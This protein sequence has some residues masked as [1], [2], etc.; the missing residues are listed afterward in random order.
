MDEMER[1]ANP[2]GVEDLESVQAE[3][4]RVTAVADQAE[5]VVRSALSNASTREDFTR[6]WTLLHESVE[7]ASSC[8]GR[9]RGLVR[10]VDKAAAEWE[11]SRLYTPDGLRSLEAELRSATGHHPVKG[12]RQWMQRLFDAVRASEMDGLRRIAAMDLGLSGTF[13]DGQAWIHQRIQRFADNDLGTALE[14]MNAVADAHVPGWD[15]VFDSAT[16]SRAHRLAALVVT[17][18]GGDTDE[19]LAHLNA[20]VELD[21]ASAIN[22]ADRAALRLFLGDF[23]LAAADAERAIQL[24]ETEPGGHLALGTW[25][26]LTGELDEAAA[27][28]AT[29]ARHM[30]LH[31]LGGINRRLS[32]LDPTGL[33]LVVAGEGLLAAERPAP[34]LA[35]ADTSL[36]V[37]VQGRA[38]YADA[39]AH[40]LR[41]RALA[42]LD[43]PDEAASA[44]V[45]CAERLLW[46][47]DAQGA[48]EELRRAL[49][50]NLLNT[51][52]R[53][54]L[55][56]GLART[57]FPAGAAAPDP[58]VVAEARGVW[59]ESAILTGP[60]AGPDS[61]AYVTSAIL[62]NYESQIDPEQRV[63]L[64]LL[65]VVDCER[66]IVHDADECL[67]WC[68]LGTFLASLGL[69]SLA[70]EAIE[71]AFALDAL[72][73]DVLTERLAK[74]ANRGQLDAA[75]DV[76]QQL[77]EAYGEDPWV[78]G[79]QAWIAYHRG[80]YSDALKKLDLPLSRSFDLSWYL[81]LR[82]L[83]WLA[84]GN[85]EAAQDDFRAIV[86]GVRAGR[87]PTSNSQVLIALINAQALTGG[88]ET[89][90]QQFE[91][92]RTVAST[93]RLGFA[94]AGALVALA[95]GDDDAARHRLIEAVGHSTNDRELDDLLD[96]TQRRIGL[97]P[98]H[99][100]AP[101]LGVLQE[102]REDAAHRQR[103][104]FLRS[105]SA[106]LAEAELLSIR[107][108]ALAC[109]E[110]EEQRV[111]AL[112]IEGRRAWVAGKVALAADRY[113]KLRHSAFEPEATIALTRA[114]TTLCE[115]A[116]ANADVITTRETMDRLVSLGA[117]DRI[118]Q[119]IAVA[120]AL[121]KDGAIDEARNELSSAHAAATSSRL[122]VVEQKL[123]ELEL[124]SG[125]P[126]AAARYFEGALEL[127][128]R[129]GNDH[130]HIA[131]LLTRA[132][133]ARLFSGDA[134]R[135]HADVEAAVDA[136]NDAGA[137]EAGRALVNEAQTV[138]RQARQSPQI[139]DAIDT[140]SGW[141]TQ[142][143]EA[144]ELRQQPTSSRQSAAEDADVSDVQE[145]T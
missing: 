120:G 5:R 64:Q 61:W 71:R 88:L 18:S 78:M 67:R 145:P 24:D 70:F 139:S 82:G 69:D 112:A 35:L 104:N 121:G 110:D 12:A 28:Y 98:H 106:S 123:G 39:R 96:D 108:G 6:L 25:A 62:H 55:A 1:G 20:A 65:S 49:E 144:E 130:V 103:A 11:A 43:R 131:Q 73:R 122:G 51:P 10:E 13:E 4:V 41:S 119:A 111:A 138:L 105:S 44:A 91:E 143:L 14:L 128:R 75:Y 74:L 32:V 30:T 57:A 132:A 59:E 2:Q 135:A 9:F 124:S 93:D 48:V 68:F 36:I 129:Q 23:D 116:V 46:S 92:G 95:R 125:D 89:A 22:Y 114:L 63:G 52:G 137:F 47:G 86:E 31:A 94:A 102:V 54:L 84:L 50:M 107:E 53:W 77:N 27:H 97:L 85:F 21:S 45:Q 16:R 56:D 58:E 100:Q 140:L 113:E 101:A 115:D 133:L 33:L 134:V 142:L 38:E 117:A 17:R 66:A 60:P 42:A 3:L 109:A 127:E 40:R 99:R 118:D 90:Q 19:A 15:R 72:N 141:T 80:E 26:E 8:R 37:G 87:I 34:A 29:G 136:L 83:C 81:D 76:A 79:V 126:G 7:I